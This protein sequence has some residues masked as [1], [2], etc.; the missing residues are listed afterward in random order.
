MLQRLGVEDIVYNISDFGIAEIG[1]LVFFGSDI[2]KLFKVARR[3]VQVCGSRHGHLRGQR[4]CGRDRHSLG[5][6]T[7]EGNGRL[8]V[9]LPHGLG[10]VH[11]HPT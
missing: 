4:G 11:L 1:M 5:M 2:E 10:Q 8:V 3:E 7:N 6:I 9:I